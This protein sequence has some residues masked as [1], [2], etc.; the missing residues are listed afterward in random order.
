METELGR[1]C[2]D[3][4]CRVP[5]WRK[6]V[7]IGAGWYGIARSLADARLQ[8]G[9]AELVCAVF[10]KRM[11]LGCTCQPVEDNGTVMPIL[12]PTGC[13]VHDRD[14]AH[15]AA[16]LRADLLGTMPNRPGI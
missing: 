14:L 6:I 8:L 12:I 15:V 3:P 4:T 10:H 16:R 7:D 9:A 5:Y 13:I 11:T 2:P 1:P